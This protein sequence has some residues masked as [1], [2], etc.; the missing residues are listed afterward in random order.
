MNTLAA[1][2]RR[3]WDSFFAVTF[4]LAGFQLPAVMELYRQRLDERAVFA[5]KM[6]DDLRASDPAASA[7]LEAI[8]P[9]LRAAAEELRPDGFARLR[10]F[11]ANFDAETVWRI[12]SDGYK[13]SVP[14]TFDGVVYAASGALAGLVVA[15]L[16]AALARAL[17]FRPQRRMEGY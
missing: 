6:L 15:A 16:L 4:A 11:V 10:A 7:K 5:A 14:L 3:I 2:I 17:V 9:R 8:L 13:A 12:V 1:G